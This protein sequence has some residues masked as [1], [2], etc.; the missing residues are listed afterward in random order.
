[1][2]MV[3]MD[4]QDY[5]DKALTLLT[6]T[7]TYKTIS[8]YPTTRLRNRLIC[9]LKDIKQQGGLSDTTYRKLYPTSAVPPGFM[10]FPKSTKQAPPW[11]P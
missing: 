8:K 4:I 7:S 11:D 10:A 2:A 6:D 5:R 9:T 1:M 3:V